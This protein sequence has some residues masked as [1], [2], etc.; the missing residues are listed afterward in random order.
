MK[1]RAINQKITSKVSYPR[2]SPS[3]EKDVI[4][5]FKD[6]YLEEMAA[7][8]EFDGNIPRFRADKII[9]DQNP[10]TEAER[11]FRLAIN[12]KVVNKNLNPSTMRP[13]HNF[14][15]LTS[16]FRNMILT[17]NQIVEEISAGHS[18]CCS[19]LKADA[20]GKTK[21]KGSS[22]IGAELFAIDVDEGLRLEDCFNK[23]ETRHACIIYTTA[24]HSDLHHRY[25]LIFPLPRLII[26]QE[27]YR[28][29][30]EHFVRT[31]GADKQCTDPVRAFYGNTEAI[32]K[33]I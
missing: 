19:I 26:Q 24:R 8:M 3:E 22:F 29:T 21:R 32:I 31:Y 30:V 9:I 5:F 7:I 25:R 6:E 2:Y 10:G 28:T 14:S 11:L 4:Y 12:R 1:T 27:H 33:I 17:V 23:P 18:L 15:I 16:G 20:D 13:Y